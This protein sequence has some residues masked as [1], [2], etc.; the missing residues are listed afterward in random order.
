VLI[1]GVNGVVV[2]LASLHFP[3]FFFSVCFNEEDDS[4][5]MGPSLQR[6]HSLQPMIG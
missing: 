3:A 1:G 4:F 2:V 5:L 6:E